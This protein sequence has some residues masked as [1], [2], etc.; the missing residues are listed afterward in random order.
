MGDNNVLCFTAERTRLHLVT[1]SHIITVCSAAQTTLPSCHHNKHW[2]QYTTQSFITWCFTPML[3]PARWV[4]WN[5][6]KNPGRLP[7]FC[8][9]MTS[10]GFLHF[11]FI[12]NAVVVCQLT[13]TAWH[14]PCQLLLGFFISGLFFCDAFVGE[15]VF[16]KTPIHFSNYLFEL[17]V[18]ALMFDLEL[19][20]DVDFSCYMM[21]VFG[22][23]VW[24]FKHHIK[25]LSPAFNDAKNMLI[26]IQMATS[27][28]LNG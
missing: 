24:I 16:W 7:H 11:G 26:I 9:G 19:L 17:D 8:Q 25:P 1:T 15:G 22:L 18:A 6:C 21:W 23:K 3:S 2:I 13:S 12:T 28:F 20:D 14:N 4:K 10:C 5:F 27:L